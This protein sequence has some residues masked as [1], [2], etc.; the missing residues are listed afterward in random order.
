MRNTFLLQEILLENRIDDV[1]KKYPN[2]N[3]DII[4]RM[5]TLD[6]SG[7]N[8][9]LDFMINYYNLLINENE[10]VKYVKLFH[11]NVNKLSKEVLDEVIEKNR[12]EWL[13]SDNSP[14]GRTL[15]GIYK[16]P[17]D[18][19]LY[20]DWEV[21]TIITDFV[22]KKLSKTEIFRHLPVL[23]AVVQSSGVFEGK[24]QKIHHD[25][26]PNRYVKPNQQGIFS[27]FQI[28]QPYQLYHRTQQ[29]QDSLQHSKNRHPLFQVARLQYRHIQA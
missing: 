27:F 4:E 6:P 10:I 7:N 26:I 8:K 19:N 12:W 24:Y 5:S 14:I 25:L 1:K 15:Q 23:I 29:Q 17:K 2:V 28:E 16:S 11:T 9:Y 22:N 13:L 21:F 20:K 18:I 3:A